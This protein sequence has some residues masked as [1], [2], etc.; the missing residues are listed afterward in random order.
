MD[1]F[2]FRTHVNEIGRIV[3]KEMAEN[4]DFHC[5]GKGGR[6][7]DDLEAIELYFIAYR[8]GSIKEAR[9][10]EVKAIQ[11]L[12][13]LIN[14]DK[15]LHPFFR[16]FPFPTHRV[17]ISLSFLQPDGKQYSD[18]SLDSVSHIKGILYYTTNDPITNKFVDLH[19][20]T[21]E[22]AQ[23]IIQSGNENNEK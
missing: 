16:E 19:Q 12:T 9:G 5:F 14:Q 7:S 21:F 13:E 6:M 1:N 11:R 2:D 23:K 3:I 22:E 18:G 15:R 4:Y 10:I 8:K 17:G 20:E